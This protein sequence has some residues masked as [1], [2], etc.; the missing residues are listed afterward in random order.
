MFIN[1][2]INIL[3]KNFKFILKLFLNKKLT[4]LRLKIFYS[5]FIFYYN[6]DLFYIVF[7]KF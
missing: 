2:F 5:S 6:F 4:K 1:L 3:L 7:L